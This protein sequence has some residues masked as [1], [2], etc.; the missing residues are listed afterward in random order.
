MR[1]PAFCVAALGAVFLCGTLRAEET[2]AAKIDALIAAK[3]AGKPASKAADDAEFCR[4]IYL[5]LAGRVPSATEVR[6]F[7]AD[8]DP[9]K[10][11]KLIDKLLASPEHPRRMADW[12]HLMFLERR[13]D[14]PAWTK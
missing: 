12:F 6:E 2:L 1:G 11:S 13:G 8:K 3:A 9:D 10:R 7:L 4:R 14:D 5:D